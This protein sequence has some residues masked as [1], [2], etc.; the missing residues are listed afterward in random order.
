MVKIKIKNKKR[1]IFIVLLLL[2][3]SIIIVQAIGGF[4]LTKQQQENLKCTFGQPWNY[5]D[6]VT[7]K[8]FTNLKL[9]CE[10]NPKNKL[11]SWDGRVCINDEEK[12]CKADRLHIW[13]GNKCIEDEEAMCIADKSK[14]WKDGECIDAQIIEINLG[15]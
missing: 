14:E 7:S 15:K 8:C 10:L 11:K 1:M 4:T 13:D 2:S 12:I 9:E 5:Y 3:V 6:K